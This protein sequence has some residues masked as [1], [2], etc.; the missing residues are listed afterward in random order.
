MLKAERNAALKRAEALAVEVSLLNVAIAD[1]ESEIARLLE[2]IAELRT[3]DPLAA[4][5]ENAASARANLLKRL[6]ER[7]QER[8]PGI[9]VTVVAADGVIR[10]RGRRPFRVRAMAR[11]QRQHGRTGRARG[12]GCSDRYASL[13]HGG[14]PR[15]VRY[16]MQQRP[17]P[18]SRRFRSKDIPTTHPSAPGFVNESGCWT[19]VTSPR[20]EAPR[21]C[22]PQPIDTD[23]N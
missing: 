18:P 6:A 16:D 22:E 1:L 14:H 10:F 19:T 17:L 20:A 15:H 21:L 3:P 7:I 11:P 13:L 9:R 8:L 4:Y 2:R 12:G 23:R 5:L